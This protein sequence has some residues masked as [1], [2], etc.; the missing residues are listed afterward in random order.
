MSNGDRARIFLDR[1]FP[2]AMGCF[3]LLE[4][5]RLRHDTPVLA[6][7][8]LLLAL[9]LFASAIWGTAWRAFFRSRRSGT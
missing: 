5:T 8:A 9:L 1:V 3:V 2:A 6:I 7:V 4:A